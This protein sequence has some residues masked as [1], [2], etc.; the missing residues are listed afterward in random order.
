[1]TYSH[2]KIHCEHI[3]VKNAS[4]RRSGD[5]GGIFGCDRDWFIVQYMNSWTAVPSYGGNDI[6]SS[7][8]LILG[9]GRKFPYPA[10]RGNPCAIVGSTSKTPKLC[11][12]RD[13]N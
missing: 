5:G 11:Q 3:M 4:G 7:G 9:G 10:Q 13:S 2:I 12:S 6:S 8:M 1:M